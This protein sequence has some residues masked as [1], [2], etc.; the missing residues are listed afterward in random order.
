MAWAVTD[1]GTVQTL[2]SAADTVVPSFTPGASKLLVAWFS[3]IADPT[4][5]SGHGTWSQIGSNLSWDTGDQSTLRVYA[6]KTSGSPSA[7]AVTFTHAG[8]WHRC[9]GVVEINEDA[10]GL[11]SAVADCFGTPGTYVAY[12]GGSPPIALPVTLGAFA[13]SANLAIQIGVSNSGGTDTSFA[14]EAT[15]TEVHE[16]GT[17][18]QQGAFAYKAGQ[19]TSPSMTSDN[20]FSY[21]A[22]F[23]VEVKKA[24]G[25]SPILFAQ[26]IC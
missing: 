15:W 26:G 10:A 23:A 14:P 6:C 16:V 24:G 2:D 11:P 1:R 5:V 4:A 17:T 21:A 8:A 9:A 3:G 20:D 22:S 12:L 25:A 7:S 13:D 19:D 18:N